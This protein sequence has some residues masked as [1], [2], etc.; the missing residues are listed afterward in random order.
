MKSRKPCDLASC[1][2]GNGTGD[3]RTCA[4]GSLCIIMVRGGRGGLFLF[5]FVEALFFLLLLL[6]SRLPFRT[7]LIFY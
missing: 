5:S 6:L 3:G 7:N 2:Y 4:D 1:S